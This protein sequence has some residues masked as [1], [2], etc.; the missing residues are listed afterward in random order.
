MYR[1]LEICS[2]MCASV[3]VCVCVCVCVGGSE[4]GDNGH[5]AC[6]VFVFQFWLI[7]MMILCEGKKMNS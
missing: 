2:S 6:I 3:S 1:S 7:E 4:M 5:S